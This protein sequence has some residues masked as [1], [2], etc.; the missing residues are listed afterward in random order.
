MRAAYL[1]T[2]Y[3]AAGIV[4]RI[5][6]RSAAMDALLRARRVRRAG[7]VTAWNPFS[8][9]TPQGWNERMNAR[10]REVAR[11]RVL[12]EGW[13]SARGWREAH[14][15]VAGNERWLACVARR[16]RQN[17]FVMVAPGQPARIVLGLAGR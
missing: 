11:G 13:G 12:A 7:F 6:K 9:R 10:L 3:E 14:L 4:V 2:E 15:L 8:R 16:F 1:R 5:G 17:A